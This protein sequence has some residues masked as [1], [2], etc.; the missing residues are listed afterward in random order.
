MIWTNSLESHLCLQWTRIVS[1]LAFF[2]EGGEGQAQTDLN[3]RPIEVV[4]VGQ[5]GSMR[6]S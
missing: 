4:E 2:E 6:G 5:K 1:L 3:L